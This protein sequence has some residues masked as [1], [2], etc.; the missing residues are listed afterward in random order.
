MSRSCNKKDVPCANSASLSISPNRIPPCRLRPWKE[1]T[2]E[3]SLRWSKT[4][5]PPC[6]MTYTV[7]PPLKE[8]SKD[9]TPKKRKTT[10]PPPPPPPRKKKGKKKKKTTINKKQK[11]LKTHGV[12]KR[13]NQY[14]TVNVII[15]TM[16]KMC[17]TDTTNKTPDDTTWL[18]AHSQSDDTHKL[19]SS[20]TGGMR[21][22]KTWRKIGVTCT[23][24][25]VSMSIGPV[26]RTWNKNKQAKTRLLTYC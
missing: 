1:K 7:N 6:C 12:R 25:W 13:N 22:K 10:N 5:A 3:T 4:A 19:M 23:G 2:V 26:V 17:P 11:L 14:Q 15:S 16:G 8:L 20:H 21:D 9:E 24:W 18:T